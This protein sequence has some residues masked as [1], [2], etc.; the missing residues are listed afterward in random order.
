MAEPERRDYIGIRV[1]IFRSLTGEKIVEIKEPVY[2]KTLYVVRP[3]QGE[4]DWLWYKYA[5]DWE[6]TDFRLNEPVNEF[7]FD[8]NYDYRIHQ[9]AVAALNIQING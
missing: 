8:S 1:H 7:D 9:I 6:E 4:P 5:D 3:Y 2:K